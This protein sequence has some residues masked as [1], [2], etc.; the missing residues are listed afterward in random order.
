[1]GDYTGNVY[2][3]DQ[4]GN[5]LASKN[6]DGSISA[7][8]AVAAM[9]EQGRTGVFDARIDDRSYSFAITSSNSAKW[10]ALAVVPTS[11]FFGRV[12]AAKTLVFTMLSAPILIGVGVG[13]LLPVPV[14]G[15]AA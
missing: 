4:T 5:V 15:A 7:A 10:T 9:E 13:L 12:I 6:S 11:Q 1:M 14:L 8:D 2:L 3:L